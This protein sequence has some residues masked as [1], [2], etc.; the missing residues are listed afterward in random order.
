MSEDGYKPDHL[1]YATH[2][3]VM[4][5]VGALSVV[6]YIVTAPLAL[7]G[8]LLSRAGVEIEEPPPPSEFEQDE[9]FGYFQG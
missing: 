1:A 6:V 5:I 3:I 2:G 9:Y 8:Y 7:V 4:L